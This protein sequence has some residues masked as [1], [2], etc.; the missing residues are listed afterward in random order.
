MGGPRGRPH[1]LRPVRC[2]PDLPGGPPP[3]PGAA[4]RLGRLRPEALRA[5]VAA[6]GGLHH[7][8]GH[9]DAARA[10]LGG[11]GAGALDDRHSPR[12]ARGAPDAHGV[13]AH[14]QARLPQYR[15]VVVARRGDLLLRAAPDDPRGGPVRP[16]ADLLAAGGGGPGGARHHR[17]PRLGQLPAGLHR[18]RGHG[19]GLGA[20]PRP[21]AA[22]PPA[23]GDGAGP[24]VPAAHHPGLVAGNGEPHGPAPGQRGHPGGGRLPGP[25]RG[26][27]RGAAR[28]AA[29][30]HRAVPGA[31]VLLPVPGARAG[32][33]LAAAADA[34]DL[35]MVGA[36][37]GA[38]GLSAA[39]LAVP[40]LHRGP[41]PPAGPPHRGPGLGAL[42]PVVR[43][44]SPHP[45][46][47]PQQEG[48]GP[49]RPSAPA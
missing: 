29:L 7:L 44:P 4:L 16:L 10:A 39:D 35:A 1:L 32:R 13:P 17:Q 36:H 27:G 28:P 40:A 33:G 49:W 34:L 21:G 24:G 37:P 23:L 22:A 3:R 46:G 25:P 47:G 18:R 6:G 31:H 38:V 20:Q 26:A 2:G 19:L 42:R 15:P 30:A 8:R 12:G 45:A 41:Q 11:S 14:P 9:C 5:P 48:L 43:A